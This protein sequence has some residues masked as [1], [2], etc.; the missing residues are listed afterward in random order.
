MLPDG[1]EAAVFASGLRGPR[2]M[3]VA[4]DGTLLVAERGADRVV[5][6]PDTDADGRADA[7]R[8]V[9][10]GFGGLNSIAFDASD[11]SLLVAGDSALIRLSLDGRLVES[12]RDTIVADLPSDDK[13]GRIYRIA[14]A[15]G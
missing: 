8:E 11:G 4:P 13:S 5:A 2:F 14:R 15:G 3:A 6:L 9:A 10:A 7:T 12:G 1:F